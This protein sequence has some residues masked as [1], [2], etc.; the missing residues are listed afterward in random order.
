MVF[1]ARK[2]SLR[3]LCFYTCLSVH[4]G[5]WYPS[6]HC[7]SPGPHPGGKL[8]GLAWGGGG[9]PGPHLGGKLRGLAWGGLQAHTCRGL[10][11]HIWGVSRS[12]PGGISRPTPRG[13]FRPTP[14][15]GLLAH[16]RGGGW[17]SQHAL[18][19]A[20][21]P[22][23]VDGYCYGRYASYWNAFLF[24]CRIVEFFMK[25]HHCPFPFNG[26]FRQSLNRNCAGNGTNIMPKYG[27]GY[28]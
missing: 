13:G 10:Q 14:S 8:R 19:Q 11:A 3:R 26:L 18:R 15:G 25:L 5:G 22:Q 27:N 7:R 20:P 6:M 1:T 16:T 23:A 9:S 4:T 12:T 2:R 24:C 28:R 17:V 21:P